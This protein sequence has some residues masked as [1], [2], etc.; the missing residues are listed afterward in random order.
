M[1]K[2]KNIFLNLLLLFFICCITSCFNLTEEYTIR[3]DGSGQFTINMDLYKMIDMM[4]SFGKSD[5]LDTKTEE[6]DKVRDTI[7]YF[8]KSIDESK[9]LSADQKQLFRDG[10]LRLVMNLKE[11]KFFLDIN[12]PFKNQ[13]DLVKIH[14]SYPDAMRSIDLK[15]AF[16][17]DTSS[18]KMMQQQDDLT[19]TNQYLE[20]NAGSNFIER[21]VNKEK[22]KEYSEKDSSLKMMLPMLGSVYISSVIHLPRPVNKVDNPYGQLSGDKKTVTFKFPFSDY[23]ERPEVMN[24]RVEY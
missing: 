20:L 14:S 19:M 22:M 12:F 17:N 7:I 23:I 4:N 5:S 18:S 11:K 16:G 3:E 6:E 21:K 13:A 2:Q 10:S 24:F 1:I 8:K 15:E 9:E